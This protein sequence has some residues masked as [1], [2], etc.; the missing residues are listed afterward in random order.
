MLLAVRHGGAFE[1]LGLVYLLLSNVGVGQ[2]TPGQI[3]TAQVDT[4]LRFL[5]AFRQRLGL[6]SQRPGD[7]SEALG[8]VGCRGE[9]LSAH[10]A[11]NAL[12]CP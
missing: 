12:E 8:G 1:G 4:A 7:V 6:L 11:L 2:K 9:F 3:G 10:R 5:P